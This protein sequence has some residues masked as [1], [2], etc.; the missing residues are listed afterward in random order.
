MILLSLV[1]VGKNAVELDNFYQASDLSMA[2]EI[3]FVNNEQGYFG[4]LG[5][6]ANYYL[7]KTQGRV[8]AMVHAD[9]TF[10]EFALLRLAETAL[11]EECITGIVGRQLSG[12]YV[13]SKSVERGGLE[14]VSTLDSSSIFIP[15]TVW[16]AKNLQ[17]DVINFDNFHC[18]IEDFCLFAASKDVL[19]K[20]P[21]AKADHEGKSTFNPE[22]RETYWSYHQRLRQKW[23]NTPFATT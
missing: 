9:T 11:R 4:G 6:I 23:S 16:K 3:I 15:K 18:C 2:P 10:E 17:F 22:W 21:Y 7:P 1:V 13:W 20:I 14:A 8:F 5:T 12:Q 19:C